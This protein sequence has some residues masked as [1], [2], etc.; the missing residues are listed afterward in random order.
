MS[1]P[2]IFGIIPA[3]GGSKRLPGKN[4]MKLGRITLLERTIRQAKKA[5]PVSIVSTENPAIL[6]EAIRCGISTLLRPDSLATDDAT[7]ADVV[8]HACRVYPGFERFCLLQVTSPLRTV[9]DIENCIELALSTARPVV[10]T[11]N[12]KPNG[13]IYINDALRF[14]GDFLK[15]AVH[16]EM[17]AERSVDIDTLEDFRR[18]EAL[19]ES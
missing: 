9:E 16:Y 5:L 3:R 10:S 18:A 8:L 13:A 11:L 17:P 4:M 14:K 15:D 12:G 7:T 1:A 6:E 19:I 2:S